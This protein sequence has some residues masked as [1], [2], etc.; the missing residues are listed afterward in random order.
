MKET[1]EKD[2]K[3]RDIKTP[4]NFEEQGIKLVGEKLYEAFLKNYTKKQWNTDPKNLPTSL[5]KRIPVRFSHDNRYFPNAK[6]QGIPVDGYTKMIEKMLAQENIDIQ[7][8]TSFKDIEPHLKPQDAASEIKDQTII[9]CGM[10]DELLDYQLGELPYRSLR[11]ETEKS[12]TS[13]GQAVVNE[14]DLDVNY[15]RTH[16]Y[17][18]YQS[19]QPE[20]VSQEAS[21]LCREF[22]ADYKR[23]AEA[24]YPVNNDE[25]EKLYNQYVALVKEKYPN[26]ILG[27]RLGAYRYWDMDQAVAN[28]LD[29]AKTLMA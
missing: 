27:G 13:L 20:I 3:A 5:L 10:V 11:F 24:Y 14:A 12:T 28:A 16:D 7:L 1:A 8:S 21:I 26:L 19:H 25:S 22:P 29:L 17:K 15:T 9:Y 6:H 4:K 23:G 18:Y 2:A